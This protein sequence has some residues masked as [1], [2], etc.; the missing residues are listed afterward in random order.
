VDK[1]NTVLVIEHQMDV[2]KTADWV[3][4][5]GPDGGAQGGTVVAAGT[6]EEVAETAASH[7]GRFL[8]EVL[9]ATAAA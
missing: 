8:R 4:D 1:G 2:V 7:T 5:L 6:P 9:P 3:I